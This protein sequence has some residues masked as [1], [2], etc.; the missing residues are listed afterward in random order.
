MNIIFIL[1]SLTI[2][3]ISV[4]GDPIQ[5]IKGKDCSFKYRPYGV[6]I[7]L[8]NLTGGTDIIDVDIDHNTRIKL[9]LC[10]GFKGCEGKSNSGTIACK[11]KLDD[12]TKDI[13]STLTKD[14][15]IVI[16]NISKYDLKLSPTYDRLIYHAR[17]YNES[18]CI[19]ENKSEKLPYQTHIE[20]YCNSNSTSKKPKYVGFNNCTYQLEWGW[21]EMCKIKAT[22]ESAIKNKTTVNVIKDDNINNNSTDSD[23]KINLEPRPKSAKELHQETVNDAKKLLHLENDQNNTNHQ[24]QQSTNNTTIPIKVAIDMNKTKTDDNHNDAHTISSNL[25]NTKTNSTHNPIPMIGLIIISLVGFVILSFVLEKKTRL[26]EIRRR[27][28][29]FNQQSDVPYTR[30]EIRA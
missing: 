9:S 18:A 26:G 20:F 29:A 22:I 16:G 24:Q 4:L 7:N 6:D 13:N 14:N 19:P 1:L 2:S 23:L 5:F 8:K 12:K 30:V 11:I 21:E 3:T 28:L 10:R 25:K 15:S 27:R 17:T